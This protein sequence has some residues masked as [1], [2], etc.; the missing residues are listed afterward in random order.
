MGVQSCPT[1]CDPMDYSLPCSSVCRIIQ[2]R[3]LEYNVI[4]LLQGIFPIQGSNK[5]FL[6]LLHWQA[7]CLPLSY[8]GSLSM[9]FSRHTGKY[10]QHTG[11]GC[12]FLIQTPTVTSMISC[13]SKERFKKK[14][15]MCWASLWFSGKES[16][17]QC[18]RC[19]FHPWSRR[20]HMQQGS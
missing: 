8:L 20:S 7:D 2:A 16:A 12:H 4:S 1:L 18:R 14:K 6:H 5:H 13:C 15:K 3:I 17:C 10:W 19:S 11:V 9:E